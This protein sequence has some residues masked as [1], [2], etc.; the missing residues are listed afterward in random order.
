VT[1]DVAAGTVTLRETNGFQGGKAVH[2]VSLDASNPVAA[3]L[4]SATFAP[5]LDAAPFAGGDWTDQ[6]RATLVGFVNG[7]TGAGNPQR[8]GLNSALLDGLDPLNLLRWNPSQGRSVRSGTSTSPRGRQR[9]SRE[10]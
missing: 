10:G 9:P 2:Y 3:T 4:E 1:I 7:Q 6:S 5:A 8:Q